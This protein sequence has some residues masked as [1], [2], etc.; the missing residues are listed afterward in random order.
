M[1]RSENLEWA[2]GEIWQI[3]NILRPVGF[4]RFDKL[5]GIT[6]PE[7]RTFERLVT[8]TRLIQDV[9]ELWFAAQFI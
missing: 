5:R 7:E 6:L 1:P 9:I 4:E 8:V 2:S 3:S